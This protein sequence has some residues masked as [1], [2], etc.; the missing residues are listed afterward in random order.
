MCRY[1]VTKPEK[2][3]SVVVADVKC[4]YLTRSYISQ[5]RFQ[6]EPVIQHAGFPSEVDSG[7][8]ENAPE[9][10]EQSGLPATAGVS[11]LLFFC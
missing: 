3:C 5:R 10:Q 2:R 11:C 9:R 6:Q 1:C 8:S 7:E 4:M